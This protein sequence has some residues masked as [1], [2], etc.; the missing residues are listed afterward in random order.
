MKIEC[1]K[2]RLEAGISIAEKITGKNLP[3]PVLSTVVI[4]GKQNTLKLKATN[5][6]MGV[7]ITIPA[8]VKE[9]GAVAVPGSLIAR[10]LGTLGSFVATIE[11]ELVGGN[12]HLAGKN[13]S[14]LIKSLPVDDF[15]TIPRLTKGTSD[16]GFKIRAR[17]FVEGLK[18]VVYA[19]SQSDI[20]PEIASVA[21]SLEGKVAT[22]AATD[23][24]RLAEK[25]IELT[26]KTEATETPLLIPAKNILDIIRIFES[27]NGDLDVTYNKNQLALSSEDVYFTTRLVAGVFPDYREII[28]KKASTSTEILKED[29]A[30]ALKISSLFSDKFNQV[31]LKIIPGEKLFEVA[32]RSQDLGETVLKVDGNLEGESADLNFNGRYIFD[33]L[34][35]IPGDHVLLEASGRER[36]LLL[37]G[38]EDKSFVYLV[39]PLN[40]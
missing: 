3:L 36:P 24:F 8:K 16:A 33:C 21:L 5:L 26:E 20:K 39:M 31:N 12:I 34:G 7:E 11:M 22:F 27:E 23:S 30:Q 6:D 17:K 1:V 4:E 32:S 29:L 18:A 15:P 9:P 14:T 13:S 38:R 37:R 19:A 35:S 10:F 40:K 2:E 25:K 28:P